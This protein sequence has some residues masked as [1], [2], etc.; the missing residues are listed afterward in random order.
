M[1]PLTRKKTLDNHAIN[2]IEKL[3]NFQ[4]YISLVKGF[5]GT[6]VLYLPNNYYT[7]GY[8]FTTL[9]IIVSMILTMWCSSLLLTAKAELGAKSYPDIGYKCFGEA[10]KIIT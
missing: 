9:A 8:G 3:N 1:S 2:K 4:V 5:I 10:G 6:A 7:G